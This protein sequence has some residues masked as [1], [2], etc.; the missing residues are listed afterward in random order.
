[1]R[2]IYIFLL[3][4][5]REV[6]E[7]SFLAKPAAAFI[8]LLIL[9]FLAWLGHYLTRQII[10]RIVH[11][12]ARKSKTQWDDFMVNRRVFRNLAHLVPAFILYHAADFSYPVIH[13]EL[14]ELGEA[15][16]NMLAKDYYFSLA[17]LLTKTAQVYFVFI[18]IF[19]LNSFLNAALD[20]YNTTPYAR[21]RPIKGYVQ[22]FKILIF[23]LSG[24]LIISI[25]LE[26]DPTV[27]LAGLGAM[28][29]VLL[30]IFKDSIL[31]FVASIQLSGNNMVKIGDWVEMRSR[32]ADGTVI[33]ITLN[34][35]KVQNWDRTIST[36][37]TYSMVSESFINWKGME[38]SGGRRI[39][40]AVNIDMN[41]IKLC[42]T[43]MLNR[44]EKFLIIKDYVI[45]KE[46]EIREY[47]KKKN[48]SDEDIVSGRRQTN[49]GVFRKYLE[50]YLHQHPMVNNDMTFLV[51]HLHPSEKGLP[52]EIYVFCK[53]KAW[54]RYESIQADIFDHVLAVIPEFDLRVFQEP[55]GADFKQ[56]FSKT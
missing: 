3:E 31:G 12:I 13:Q 1:M 46:K 34:T 32:G 8:T 27:L 44:L 39:K 40:R 42:D 6:S 51:R 43:A 25:L 30:L 15:T 38:E 4:N 49:I 33:D 14:T 37:P 5:I 19:A 53:D 11:R 26:R 7:L 36:I 41:S 52:I 35:V 45:E 2:S 18:F 54:A 22:L 56:A 20:I 24:I 55:S 17:G 23:S 48:I 28:G 9:I 21:H 10:L 47:N 16:L 50:T 29:A